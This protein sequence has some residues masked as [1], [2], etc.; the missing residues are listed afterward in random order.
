M[1]TKKK[2]KLTSSEK[3]KRNTQKLKDIGFSI[4]KVKVHPDDSEK[5]RN[6][7]AK[8]PKTKVLINIYN[9][10]LYSIGE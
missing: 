3:T 2:A 1:A 5:V 6:Y 8:Q 4:I 7:A 9:E 10:S